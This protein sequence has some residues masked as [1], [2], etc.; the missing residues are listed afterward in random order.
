MVGLK[1]LSSLLSGDAISQLKR[2][3]IPV[4]TASSVTSIITL[5]TINACG[6]TLSTLALLWQKGDFWDSQ[7]AKTLIHG[8]PALRETGDGGGLAGRSGDL[9]GTISSG[10]AAQDPGEALPSVHRRPDWSR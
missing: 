8:E 4:V 5:F 10:F 6:S 7:E 1:S 2:V 9:A 3:R